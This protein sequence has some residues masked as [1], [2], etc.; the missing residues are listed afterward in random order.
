MVLK[1]HLTE[2]NWDIIGFGAAT[3]DGLSTT[4]R[5]MEEGERFFLYRVCVHPSGGRKRQH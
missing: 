3:K 4:C 5:F 1:K 2:S